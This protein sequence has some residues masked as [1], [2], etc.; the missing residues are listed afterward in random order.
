MGKPVQRG[1]PIYQESVR[2]REDPDGLGPLCYYSGNPSCRMHLAISSMVSCSLDVPIIPLTMGCLRLTPGNHAV[3]K[4][5]LYR[6]LYHVNI[7][8]MDG[9]LKLLQVVAEV[10]M[11]LT[12]Y[13]LCLLFCVQNHTSPVG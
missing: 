9:T 2:D 3:P 11:S 13:S 8:Y 12:L 6:R 10:K 7:L 5:G 1:A 4:H